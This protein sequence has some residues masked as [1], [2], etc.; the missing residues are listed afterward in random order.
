MA[1]SSGVLEAITER[2]RELLDDL[3]LRDRAADLSRDVQ[4][5]RK[6][7]RKRSKKAVKRTRKLT[8]EALDRAEDLRERVG[9]PRERAAE[10][11]EAAGEAS[12]V[13]R[14]RAEDLEPVL[15][16]L[17]IDLLTA[18][19]GLIGVLM[20]VPRLI[21]RG[22]GFAGDLIDRAEVAREKGHE[23]SER[24][25]DVAHN[26]PLSRRMR[27]R[28]RVSTTLLVAIAFAI[29]FAVGWVLAQR[30]MDEVLEEVVDDVRP[31]LQP[32]DDPA[33]EAATDADHAEPETG[34][35]A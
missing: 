33:D 17:A 22:L 21:V 19:R 12:E 18:I 16:K 31:P 20:A 6:D 24:A 2:P 27:W 15:R 11:R 14:D 25:L 7:L 34:T 13:V 5:R 1:S 35:G 30:A 26:L 32:V 23:Y 10:L 28:R 9:D 3:D 8:A 4:K 29:G